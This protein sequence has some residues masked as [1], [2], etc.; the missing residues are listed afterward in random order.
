MRV[1]DAVDELRDALVGVL[2]E[3]A[4]GGF[5]GIGHHEDTGLFGEGVGPGIGEF[6]LVD[7]AV[8]V[9]VAIGVVEELGLTLAVVGGYEVFNGLGQALLVCHFQSVVHVRDDNLGALLE[10]E[11]GV[12]V[13][14]R[15][16][17]GEEG[18]VFQLADVVVEGAGTYQLGFGSN[19]VGRFGGEVG[20]LQRMLEGAGTLLGEL[21]QYGVVYIGELD[22][23][24]G[25][26]KS[27]GFLEDVDEQVGK[28]QEH[29]VDAEVDEH[30]VVQFRQV[31]F[32]EQ[33]VAYV[34]KAVGEEYEYGAA[35]ELRPAG[36]VAEA[37]DGGHAHNELQEDEF[38]RKGGGEGTDEYGDEVH[39]EGRARIEE[40]DNYDG[41]DGKGH[42][43]DAL[44]AHFGEEKGDEREPYDEHHDEAEGAH[45]VEGLRAEEGQ[46]QVE[47]G[48]EAGE[49]NDLPDDGVA[50]VVVDGALFERDGFERFE[51]AVGLRGDDFAPVYDAFAGLH[52]AVG[53][54][55][56]LQQV[57]FEPVGGDAVE[58]DV[59]VEK[60]VEVAVLQHVVRVGVGES[61]N[62]ALVGFAGRL[63]FGHGHFAGHVVLDD[64][65]LLEFAR[66][67]AGVVV[68][69]DDAF[70]IGVAQ[71]FNQIPAQRGGDG[72]VGEV[73]ERFFEV[74]CRFGP[75]R[76]VE[77]EYRL[78]AQHDAVLLLLNNGFVLVDGEVERGGEQAVFPRLALLEGVA[79]FPF[80][81]EEIGNQGHRG[82]EKEKLQYSF[83]GEDF[84]YAGLI[85]DSMGLF[86]AA[87]RFLH[88]FYFS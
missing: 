85:H 13:E 83:A 11:G 16:V 68:G 1:D 5:D 87:C 74:G 8:G 21:A 53:E 42:E 67:Q 78:E 50:P 10:R 52:D 40:G 24:D 12:R 43:V 9:F 31:A 26:D 45:L 55:D 19:L 71:G 48:E 69:R 62:D 32:G 59:G 18:G 82:Y 22:Q 36:E 35:H 60:V 66:L 72:K 25:G 86:F 44:H 61:V 70:A 28:E 14:S 54:G 76:V 56:A 6:R 47:E 15:L 73:A 81:G 88:A 65:Y 7:R 30:V 79:K 20:D 23:R 34:G 4:R 63:Q 39:V 29:A 2:F 49:D 27:E 3:A 41:Y 33:R 84:L 38:E 58:G 17:F 57:V 75:Y 64:A 51:Y 46:K 37:V 80:A 77:R